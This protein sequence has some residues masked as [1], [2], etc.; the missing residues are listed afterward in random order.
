MLIMSLFSSNTEMPV[1]SKVTRCG[2]FCDLNLKKTEEDMMSI[3]GANKSTTR[4][5]LFRGFKVSGVEGWLKI[6]L[7]CFEC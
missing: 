5:S 2:S 1:P 3:T 7:L 6:N 4:A